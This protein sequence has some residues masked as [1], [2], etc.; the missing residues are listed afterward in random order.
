MES[1]F[2]GEENLRLR[3]AKGETKNGPAVIVENHH[4]GPLRLSRLRKRWGQFT[5][6]SAVW[7]DDR[8][9]I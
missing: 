3:I 4:A 8:M 1:R 6:G 9:M 7:P 5:E 2:F